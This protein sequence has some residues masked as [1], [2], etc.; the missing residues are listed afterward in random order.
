MQL[1]SINNNYIL[2]I[3]I[4]DNSK[5]SDAVRKRGVKQERLNAKKGATPNLT[6][7]IIRS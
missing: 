3:K 5:L 7:F 2:A 4:Y 1:S 6:Y